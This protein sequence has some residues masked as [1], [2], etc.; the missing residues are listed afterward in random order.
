M[1]Q[2]FG[3]HKAGKLPSGGKRPEVQTWDLND[4]KVAPQVKAALSFENKALE[5][6]VW[7]HTQENS[8]KNASF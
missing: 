8:Q 6:M 4:A 7:T 2:S 3:K 1:G 5:R